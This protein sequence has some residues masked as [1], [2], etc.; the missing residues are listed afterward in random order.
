[1]QMHRNNEKRGIAVVAV[2]SNMPLG[3]K[4]PTE[5]VTSS[6]AILADRLG[7]LHKSSGLYRT[8]AF[9]AGS[10][11]DF[12]N[13]V[14]AVQTSLGAAQVLD[15]L[16]VIESEFGR[17]RKKRWGQRTLDLDLIALDGQ[18]LPDP[19]AH[20]HWRDLPLQEQAATTPTELVLPHP[21][22]QDRSF[23]LVP[24]A[25]ILPDWRHPSLG[26]TV[27]QMLAARPATERTDVRPILRPA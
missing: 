14:V 19:V 5:T 15:L 1:M 17:T 27:A 24:M 8:P 3:G 20:A 23:V 10:G 11:P 18:V 4:P 9:P 7:K 26:L 25:E 16:H 22:L 2:G 13:A 12:V 21:R 6:I